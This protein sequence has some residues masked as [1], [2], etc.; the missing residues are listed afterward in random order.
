MEIRLS[1]LVTK[2]KIREVKKAQRRYCIATLYITS[3]A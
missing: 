1:R 2:D 3:I